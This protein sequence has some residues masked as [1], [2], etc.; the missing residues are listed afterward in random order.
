[1]K[2]SY[3]GRT[4]RRSEVNRSVIHWEYLNQ[5]LPLKPL[6]TVCLLIQMFVRPDGLVSMFRNITVTGN[7]QLDMEVDYRYQVLHLN[8]QNITRKN[9]R[10]Q[11]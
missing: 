10:L 6:D 8:L 4:M 11:E 1:M 5:F 3:F 9:F 2:L 7:E